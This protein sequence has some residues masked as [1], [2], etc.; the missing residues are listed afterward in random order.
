ML[1]K[2]FKK[3]QNIKETKQIINRNKKIKNINMT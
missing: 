2:D 1:T 3:V